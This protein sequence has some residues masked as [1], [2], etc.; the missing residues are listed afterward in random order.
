MN[1]KKTE[2]TNYFVTTKEVVEDVGFDRCWVYK[3]I[4]QLK[5]KKYVAIDP[6]V[7]PWEPNSIGLS[8]YGEIILNCVK[9]EFE[10]DF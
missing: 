8:M 4:R 10:K 1:F 3:C 7:S 9:R 6:T 5:E 2:D